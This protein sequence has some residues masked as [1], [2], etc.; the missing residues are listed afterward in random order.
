MLEFIQ[1]IGSLAPSLFDMKQLLNFDAY[2]SLSMPHT[3]TTKRK[4]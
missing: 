4:G 3:V 1:K 2:I